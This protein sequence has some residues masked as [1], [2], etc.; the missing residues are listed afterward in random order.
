[1]IQR[2]RENLDRALAREEFY[3][4]SHR[5]CDLI[6][7]VQRANTTM[8]SPEEILMSEMDIGKTDLRSQTTKQS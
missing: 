4:D 7:S 3:V 2:S 1:M 5:V 6:T 8:Q